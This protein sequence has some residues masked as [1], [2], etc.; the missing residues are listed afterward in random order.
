[1]VLVLNRIYFPEGTQGSLEWNGALVCYT[2]ELPWLGNQR[3]ISCIPEGE[4]VLKKRY[5]K[6]FGWHLHVIYVSGRD[7]I[8]I[9]PANNAKKELLGCIAPVTKHTGIGKGSSS[10][11]AL[12]KLKALVYA[13]LECNIVVKISIQSAC[14]AQ[15]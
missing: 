3:R 4:Y 12:K 13:A 7:L 2:I 10:R 1:M 8:L 9:H 5:S 11:I 14:S 6:K 15:V